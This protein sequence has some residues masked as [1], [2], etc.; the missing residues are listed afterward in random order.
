MTH[1]HHTHQLG[2]LVLAAFDEAALYST[3]EREVSRLATR[4]VMRMLGR[5]RRTRKPD[6]GGRPTRGDRHAVRPDL[7]GFAVDGAGR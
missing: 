1:I 2:E 3:D 6:R 7:P 5:V 4:A